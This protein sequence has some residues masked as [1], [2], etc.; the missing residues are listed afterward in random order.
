MTSIKA[1]NSWFAIVSRGGGAVRS[2]LVGSHRRR[3]VVLVDRRTGGFAGGCFRCRTPPTDSICL[4]RV[5]EVRAFFP[6]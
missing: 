5:S 1:K 6:H 3:R 2:P 4:V